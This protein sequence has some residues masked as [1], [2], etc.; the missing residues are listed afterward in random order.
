MRERLRGRPWGLS[1]HLGAMSEPTT[2]P[3]VTWE[4][5]PEDPDV[6]WSVLTDA[7]GAPVESDLYAWVGVEDTMTVRDSFD[8]PFATRHETWN[9]V[10]EDTATGRPLAMG[11]A[12]HE[13]DAKA[14]AA[15]ALLSAL[16]THTPF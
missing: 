11:D 3:T 2:A 16:T 12:K 8:Y 15:K 10:V 1:A 5:T 4:R 6:E 9:W 13:G 14:D 7:A